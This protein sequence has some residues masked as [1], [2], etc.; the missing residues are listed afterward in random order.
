MIVFYIFLAI[1]TCIGFYLRYSSITHNLSFWNDESQ[2]AIY[3]R[4]ILE[5]GKPIDVTGYSTGMYQLILY[6]LTALS[7]FLFGISEFAARLPSVVVGTILIPIIFFVTKKMLSTKEAL[8]AAFLMTF[9]QMQLAWSTQLR[10]YIWMELFTVITIYLAY[11]YLKNTHTIFNTSLWWGIAITIISF[12]FHGT[13]LFNGIIIGGAFIYKIIELKKY[14]YLLLLIPAALVSIIAISFTPFFEA[15]FRFNT[16]LIHYKVFLTYHYLWLCS[17]AFLG[18][19]LLWR[20]NRKLA[21]LL[22]LSAGMIIALALFKIH[23]RYVRYSIT[24]FPILYIMFAAGIIGLVDYISKTTFTRSM[25]YIVILVVF[26]MWP[27]KKEKILFT[28]QLYYT[29]NADM[30]ENPIVD[31]KGAFA[32][33]KQL[34]NG[35]NDIIIMDAWYDRTLW[36]LPGN[37]WGILFHAEV[38]II[39]ASSIKEFEQFK[40]KHPRGIAIVENW[41]SMTPPELQDHLR[42][43]LKYEFEQGAIRGNERDAWNIN[44]YSWGL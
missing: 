11:R 30:R 21:L 13:G 32:K 16:Y 37:P 2:V 19:V 1:L 39:Q 17:G 40:K 31:Y 29:I 4:A 9:S 28:P 42:K 7:F 27:V 18:F 10:P 5:L 14:K 3:S 44:V 35:R 41:Q 24:A 25:G 36:Y 22:S 12:L 26:L 23:D 6:Y 38:P 43:T 34:I 15:L 33:I 20:T 8:I